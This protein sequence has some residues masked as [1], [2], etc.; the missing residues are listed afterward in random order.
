MRREEDIVRKSRIKL[1]RSELLGSTD[2]RV[3]TL[4]LL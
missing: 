1:G 3:L 2:S 4:R